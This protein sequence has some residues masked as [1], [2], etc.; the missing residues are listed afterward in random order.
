M[1]KK[2]L[3][4][5]SMNDLKQEQEH[6]TRL[7]DL[8]GAPRRDLPQAAKIRDYLDKPLLLRRLSFRPD[9]KY[10]P[11]WIVECECEG[12]EL[13]F[14]AGQSVLLERFR[15]LADHQD[16]FP[17]EFQ[18]VRVSGNDGRSYFDIA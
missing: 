10:G 17:V 18:F 2:I 16:H 12:A 6:I 15:W 8:P 14:F 5:Q 7:S 9:G 3:E 4:E 13:S 11:F 1:A